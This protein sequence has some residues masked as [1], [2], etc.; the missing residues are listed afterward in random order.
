MHPKKLR[1]R[2]DEKKF[3]HIVNAVDFRE[4]GGEE[5]V[6]QVETVKNI[7]V[8]RCNAGKVV[9]D[10]NDVIEDILKQYIDN[11]ANGEAPYCP[12]QR[13]NLVGKCAGNH[14][15]RSQ[16]DLGGEVHHF[17]GEPARKDHLFGEAGRGEDLGAWTDVAVGKKICKLRL[18]SGYRKK[19][20]HC[21]EFLGMLTKGSLPVQHGQ[22]VNLAWRS[23]WRHSD[24]DKRSL[25]IQGGAHHRDGQAG[26]GHQLGSG[27]LGGGLGG[28]DPGAGSGQAERGDLH[29][30]PME[31]QEGRD[32]QSDDQASGEAEVCED[33][34]FLSLFSYTIFTRR[35]PGVYH[36]VGTAGDKKTARSWEHIL[37]HAVSKWLVICS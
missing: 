2:C 29:V 1:R 28:R 17:E 25:I 10:K 11:A 3:E 35:D 34:G 6:A 24:Q 30:V 23:A 5:M 32:G 4:V 31:G 20:T 13:V 12:H 16:Q 8:T 15:G 14:L 18:Y 37:F 21:Q 22:G 9:I 36:A 33:E 26:T 7:V 19:E 27:D